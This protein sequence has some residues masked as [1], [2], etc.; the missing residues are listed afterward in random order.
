M[1]RARVKV[2]HLDTEISDVTR[3][4]REVA[5]FTRKAR[6]QTLTAGDRAALRVVLEQLEALVR[7]AN[8]MNAPP[9]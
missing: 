6:P 1:H 4:L 9:A 5:D 2:H 8:S 7:T 3:N